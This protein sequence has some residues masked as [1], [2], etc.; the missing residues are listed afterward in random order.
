MSSNYIKSAFFYFCALAF[1]AS[2][3]AQTKTSKPK[4]NQ[5]GFY[6]SSIKIGVTPEVNAS[7]FY[8]RN[9][10]TGAIAFE[11]TLQSNRT[12]SP[13]DET[14]KLADFSN[15]VVP[16]MY[17]LG[18]VGGE[19]SFEFEIGNNVFSGLSDAL[20]KAFYYNRASTALLEEHAGPWARDLGHPDTNVTVHNSAASENRP[21]DSKISS[22]KGWYD[23]GDFGK[24]VVPISSSISQLLFAYEEFPDFF[25][26]RELNIPESGDNIPDILDESLWALRWLFTM[27]DPDDGGVYHKLTT[28]NF[29]GTVMPSNTNATRYVVQKG[30]AATY[31]FAA[32]MAQAARVYEPFLPNFAD[33]ALAASEEAWAWAIANPSIAY[34]QGSLNNPAINTGG[35]GDGGNYSDE[36]FWASSELYITTKNDSYYIDNG[37]SSAGTVGWSNV[38]GL[39][40]FS[41]LA[42][43]K[44]LTAIGLADT[45]AMKNKVKSIADSYV[46]SGNSSAYR[47]PFGYTNGHFYWGSNG[48]AGN[49]GLVTMLAY[50]TTGD[51]KYYNASIDVLDYMLGRNPLEQSFVTGFGENPPMKIHHRQSEADAITNPVPG[52]VAG[53]ANPG[54]QSQDCGVSAYNSTLSA[55]SYLD[56][57]CS[58]STNE[59]TTY[60]NSPFIYLTAGLEYLT[61]HFS[62]EDTKTGFF[63]AP[64]FNRIYEPGDTVSLA[65]SLRNIDEVDLYYKVFEDGEFIPLATNLM[66]S[67]S[68]Y[69]SFVVPNQ[70][71]RNIIFRVQSSTNSDVWFQS[72]FLKIKPSK[73]IYFQRIYTTGEFEPNKRITI[74]WETISVDS[75]DILYR[76]T[77]QSDFTFLEKSYAS[78]NNSYRSFRVPETSNDSL[79]FRLQDSETDTVFVE[80]DPIEIVTIV[81]NENEYDLAE[82]FS[83]SQNYPNPFNPYTTIEFTIANSGKVTLS[84]FNLMGQNVAELVNENKSKG[85]YSVV[86][87]ASNSASG[88]YYYRLEAGSNVFTQKMTLI[89]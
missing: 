81:S 24:Y 11:G 40:L 17:V 77:S 88:V 42:N 1:S 55:L 51:L 69:S 83:L 16:G 26:N 86:W 43:R 74:E 76:L 32:V 15:F 20:I 79:I 61:P 72:A 60:W 41:M 57:Y 2:A 63:T 75:I 45:A 10:S 82:Q 25:D 37:W 22:P 50:R 29:V 49:I 12:N 85:T 5:L 59:I 87:D 71:G 80:S 31:D 39:G 53:G 44:N 34:N 62:L 70:P 73:A 28:A 9:T 19:E 13:S 56:E 67:D 64:D 27:Q 3:F 35:Y 38:Q 18:I 8:I 66:A 6:P 65:W 52:W 89:K 68:T 33:S 30:T 48:F 46:N 4:V 84:V 14:L 21:A 36:K 58:Y 54:N 23:A 47:S 78:N 7:S